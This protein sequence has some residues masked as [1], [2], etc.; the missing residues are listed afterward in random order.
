M[1]PLQQDDIQDSFDQPKRKF[2]WIHI[3]TNKIVRAQTKKLAVKQLKESYNLSCEK[4]D[5]R[6]ALMSEP[7]IL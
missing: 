5:V 7:H 4:I 6:Q 1:R 3:P 2:R